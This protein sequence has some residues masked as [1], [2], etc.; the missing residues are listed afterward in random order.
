[1]LFIISWISPDEKWL[2]NY[3]KWTSSD[4][5]GYLFLVSFWYLITIDCTRAPSTQQEEAWTTRQHNY[6]KK[7]LPMMT[8]FWMT[9]LAERS[10]LIEW[11]KRELLTDWMNDYHFT[12]TWP[13]RECLNDWG[14][15]IAFQPTTYVKRL[16]FLLRPD[17]E[18]NVWTTEVLILLF[19]PLRTPP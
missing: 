5:I 15:K 17:Q 10:F 8:Q 13:R 16:P 14:T 4:R 3:Y 6:Q 1:M 19:N 18:E 7:K 11:V 12:E 2:Q 9:R